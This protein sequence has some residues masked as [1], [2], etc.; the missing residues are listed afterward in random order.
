MLALIRKDLREHALPLLYYMAVTAAFP[1]VLALIDRG[2]PSPALLSTSFFMVVIS[3]IMITHWLLN[4]EKTKR[5]LFLLR[6]LPMSVHHLA[7]AKELVALIMLISIGVVSVTSALTVLHILGGLEANSP[8]PVAVAWVFIGVVLFTELM[9]LS[10]LRF[11][12]RLAIQVPYGGL[13][14]LVLAYSAL[15][16]HRPNLFAAFVAI[17]GRWYVIAAG[18]LT[19]GLII[20]CLHLM[21]VRLLERTDW[22]HPTAE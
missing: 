9:L 2:R 12:Q 7:G 11:D 1:V 3:P 17:A 22:S 4:T 8:N 6:M 5:T 21:M 16:N 13:L 14:L 20:L 19:A 10:F 18:Y 15:R